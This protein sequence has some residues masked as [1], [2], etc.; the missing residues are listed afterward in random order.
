MNAEERARIGREFGKT[1]YEAF[2]PARLGNGTAV[3]LVL[4]SVV[5]VD[6]VRVAISVPPR[7]GD[8]S[9]SDSSGETLPCEQFGCAGNA[10]VS[11]EFALQT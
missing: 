11:G 9:C 6:S 5:T 8:V 2:F 10:R 7:P 3:T 4:D 1:T